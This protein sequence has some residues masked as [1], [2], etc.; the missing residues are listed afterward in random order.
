[1]KEWNL[2]P[3]VFLRQSNEEVIQ[4]TSIDETIF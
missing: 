1:M 4:F 2:Y 3:F